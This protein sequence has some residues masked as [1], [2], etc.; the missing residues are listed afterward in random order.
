MK[1]S[2]R[3]DMENI[4]WEIVVLLMGGM[5]TILTFLASIIKKTPE[6]EPENDLTTHQLEFVS[7][8]ATVDQ[9]IKDIK[10]D[11][12]NIKQE[13]KDRDEKTLKSIEKLEGKIEKFTDII[14]DHIRKN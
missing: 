10:S 13:I 12:N 11:L 9:Q 8:K 6:K 7:H 3:L 5:V 2:E 4:T 14:V 1:N